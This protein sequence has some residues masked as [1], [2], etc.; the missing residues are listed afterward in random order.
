MLELFVGLD[1]VLFF[2]YPS[3]FG[4]AP[5]GDVGPL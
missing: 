3:S 4:L 5:N 1:D 2:F